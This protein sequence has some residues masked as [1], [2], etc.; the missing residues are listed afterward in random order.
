MACGLIRPAPPHASLRDKRQQ[1]HSKLTQ[2][3]PCGVRKEV[4]RVVARGWKHGGK[5]LKQE[6]TIARSLA[7]SRH[8][9]SFLRWAGSKRKS[10]GL[11]G[12]SYGIKPKHYVEPFAGSAALFFE[13]APESGI[14]GDL[15]GHLI[16]ALRCV[17]DFPVDVHKKLRSF[18]RTADVY[19]EVRKTFNAS[20][21]YGIEAAA[22][23]VY[24]NRNCFNGLWRTN[25]SG[26]FNVPFGGL[27]MGDYPP[28]DLFIRCSELLKRVKIRHQ[29]FR[30]TIRESSA[31]SF[32]YADPPYFATSERIFIE[33]GKR[34]FSQEDLSDLVSSLVEAEGRGALIA[35]T[36]HDGM[37]IDGIPRR[38]HRQ[39][40]EVTRNVGG[41]KG[42]RKRQVE[43]L[44]TNFAFSGAE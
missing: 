2:Q 40:F 34:S 33:Y 28:L 42:T 9:P 32:V 14:L 23:F 13:L 11:L 30:K 43:V 18:D 4:N 38:W 21:P 29:D 8:G 31:G 22:A 12:A 25:L 44:Y 17:R 26:R 10:L 41:F 15:N 6:T 16:N 35:L 24:L 5:Y 1:R 7:T 37:K 20:P 19:Y 3:T 39:R 27:E 36:Y